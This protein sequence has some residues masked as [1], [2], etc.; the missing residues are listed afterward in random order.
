M[1]V[2]A[3]RIIPLS[4]HQNLK[5]LPAV[6]Q[7]GMNDPAWLGDALL[8]W[9]LRLT[10]LSING[11]RNAVWTSER[12]SGEA[13]TAF[14]IY[15]GYDVPKS[16]S[17]HHCATIFEYM[18][19]LDE[20]FRARYLDYLAAPPDAKRIAE[21][22]YTMCEGYCWQQ[23]FLSYDKFTFDFTGNKALSKRQLL[24]LAARSTLKSEKFGV[25]RHG[26]KLHIVDGDLAPIAII[27]SM[28]NKDRL[29]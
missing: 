13:L 27:N 3:R 21:S 10:C 8:E 20:D 6:S 24:Q 26:S 2:C 9:D 19:N 29:G 11:E 14:L 22:T 4:E 1:S 28:V 12:R 7:N 23:L 17:V 15:D 25:V 18:Y 5:E 16:H